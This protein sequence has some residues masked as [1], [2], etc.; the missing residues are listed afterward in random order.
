M[1]ASIL[2]VLLGALRAESPYLLISEAEAKAMRSSPAL[3]EKIRALCEH[4]M[5]GGPWSVTYRRPEG[6]QIRPNDYYSEG[7]YWWPDPKNPKGPY[8]RKDGERNPNRFDKNRRDLGDMANAVLALGM[9]AWLFDDSRYA[10]RAA[11]LVNTWFVDPSTRMNPHLNFG[12]AIK[13]H[14]DGRGAGIIDTVSLI[15]AAQGLALLERSGKWNATDAEAARKWFAAYLTW[16]N[17]SKNGLDEKKAQ[18]NHGTW[19]TSQVA[20]FAA[21]SHDKE[22]QR[23]AWERFYKQ[24]VPVE[25]QPDGSCPREEARTNSLSYSTMNLDGFSILCRLAE[26]DG[27]NLWKGTTLEKSFFYLKPYVLEPSKWKKQQ[28]GAYK[29]DG[30]FFLGLA[31]L[32]LK[33]NELLNAYTSLPRADSAQVLFFDFLIRTSPAFANQ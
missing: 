32:G 16:L 23:M 10:G 6:L 29:A 18:N 1:I 27:K 12:Q 3:H 20:A 30:T 2:F 17:T 33:S 13:G 8:I 28:I 22:M 11:K 24:L 5:K 4:E 19:W 14:N 9:G 21:F 31:G 15:Y 26:Q 7:P 25:I